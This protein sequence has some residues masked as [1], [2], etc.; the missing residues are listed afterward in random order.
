MCDAENALR[1]VADLINRGYYSGCSPDFEID[2]GD[3]D[4]YSIRYDGDTWGESDN[5]QEYLEDI[6]VKE[7]GEGGYD[8]IEIIDNHTGDVVWT[9]EE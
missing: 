4:R 6:A 1:E 3:D 2:F 9:T 5:S 8:Y 7:Y